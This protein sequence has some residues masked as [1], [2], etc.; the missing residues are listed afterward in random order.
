M[1]VT[2]EFM[3]TLLVTG[4]AGFIGSC[5]V[6]M[7]IADHA[8]RV[9]VLDKL[10]YAGNLDSLAPVAN[11]PTYTFVH[12]DVAD[13]EPCIKAEREPRR[14]RPFITRFGIKGQLQF[15]ALVER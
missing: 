1:F 4:G 12:G 9:V 15:A 10:T 13:E 11:D 2:G 3:K 5:F 14:L 6:R 7:M 8:A